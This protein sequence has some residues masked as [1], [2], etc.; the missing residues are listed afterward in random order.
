MKKD[1]FFSRILVPVDGSHPALHA[2]EYAAVIAKDFG[3]RVTVLHVIPHDL[4]HPPLQPYSELPGSVIQE[5]GDW[6]RQMGNKIM[7]DAEALFTEEGVEVDTRLVEHADP[8]ETI[9]QIAKNEGYNLVIM[10]NRGTEGAEDFLLGGVAEKVSHHI[11]CPIL[12]AKEKPKISK[13]LVAVD[14]SEYMKKILAC[15]VP[16][17]MKRNA[18]VTLLNVVQTSVPWLKPEMARAL[19]ERILSKASVMVG[20]MEP[21]KRVEFGHPAQA[22]LE[23]AKGEGHDLIVMGSRGLGQ[24]KRFLLGSVSER[25]SRYAHC[26]VLIVK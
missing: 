10:G 13:I 12:I 4:L 22:I 23:V 26:S 14:G 21:D 25:V 7:S 1:N 20:G 6:F 17:A 9:L 24:V 19:G 5:I 16:L 15:V 8:A 11:E 18:K 3:S 2:E